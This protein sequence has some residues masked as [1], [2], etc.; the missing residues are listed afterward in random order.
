MQASEEHQSNLAVG[1]GREEDDDTALS[2]IGERERANIEDW[3]GN[4][5]ITVGDSKVKTIFKCR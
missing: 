2:V 5:Q 3:Q 4:R 1:G